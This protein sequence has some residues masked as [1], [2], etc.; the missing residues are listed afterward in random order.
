MSKCQRHSQNLDVTE[1]CEKRVQSKGRFTFLAVGDIVLANCMSHEGPGTKFE[2]NDPKYPFLRIASVLQKADVV[3]G[4]L[5][6]PLTSRG[7][8]RTDLPDVFR[9][10]P[11]AAEGLRFAG[12]DIVSIANNHI[13]DY[14]IVGLC[15]TIEALSTHNI[16]YVGAGMNVSE[17][18]KP[19]MIHVDD[20]RTAFLAYSFPLPGP[21]GMGPTRRAPGFAVKRLRSIVRDVKSARKVA[22]IV[23]VSIHRG[24]TLEDC[25]ASIHVREAHQIADAGAKIILEHHP[26]CLQGVERYGEAVIAYGLGNFV[27]DHPM[28]KQRETAIFRFMLSK[29]GVS[30]YEFVPVYI[31]SNFQPELAVEPVAGT[32]SRRMLDM[33]GELASVD[34]SVSR[35]RDGV[36]LG[37]L[38]QSFRTGGILYSLRYLFSRLP[39]IKPYHVFVFIRCLLVKVKERH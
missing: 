11:N 3:F 16:R 5:E 2:R 7:T 35:E 19:A 23:V 15:D 30:R 39:D 31:N 36:R 27:F 22:D 38:L 17:A 9:G 13:L 28:E 14:G 33:C 34:S 1:F 8:P 26:H 24:G 29:D 6:C 32:I 21:C 4:N 37:G 12:F 25:P 18:R 10:S 20:V